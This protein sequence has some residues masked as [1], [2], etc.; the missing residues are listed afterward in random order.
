[1]VLA[2]EEVSRTATVVAVSLLAAA[3]AFGTGCDRAVASPAPP[4]MPPASPDDGVDEE[5][6]A[7]TA[8][9]GVEL[10]PEARPRALDPTA[11]EAVPVRAGGVVARLFGGEGTSPATFSYP[12]A[13]AVSPVDGSIHVIDKRGWLRRFDASGRP[14]AMVRMPVVDQG[15]PTGMDVD[16]EGRAFVAD[17]HLHRVLVYDAALNLIDAWGELGREDGRLLLVTGIDVG[18]D[19]T[20]WVTDQGADVARVQAFDR[21][22]RLIRR[23][24]RW[25]R[26][27]GELRNPVA[28]ALDPAGERIAVADSFNHR[29]Q[30]FS[31]D[32]ELLAVL[33]RLGE[34]PGE[35]KYP[36]D[37]A[38]GP[39][40]RR[41]AVAEFGNDRMSVF[42]V[43]DGRFVT[44]FGGTGTSDGQL[45]KPW[46]LAFDPTA[47]PDAARLVL[48]DSGNHRLYDLRWSV[49]LGD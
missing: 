28:V 27:D 2:E 9:A 20:V 19:G 14:L 41:V 47:P 1:M 25:G 15:T 40:G 30:I 49:L 36:Y 46:A 22:G 11:A 18:A 10:P 44:S 38:W 3:L 6:A 31:T 39:R 45:L 42:E 24:G 34:A 7:P 8:V 21:E 33:G 23:I 4:P 48:V 5:A 35:L 29:I 37:V 43:A 16:G 17:S 32:G 13:V 26:A 12:R